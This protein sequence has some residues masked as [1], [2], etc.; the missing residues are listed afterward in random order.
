M[1]RG[2]ENAVK[3]YEG[4][5]VEYDV[6][7]ITRLDLGALKTKVNGVQR[8]TAVMF[9]PGGTFLFGASDQHVILQPRRCSSMIET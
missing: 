3:F 2:G 6:I 4:R 9:E 5:F 7:E 8:T 1:Q